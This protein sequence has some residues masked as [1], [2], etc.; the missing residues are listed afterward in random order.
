MI[1]HLTSF[2]VILPFIL[3]F[4]LFC[5]HDTRNPKDSKCLN[6][7]QIQVLTNHVFTKYTLNMM[8]EANK[9]PDLKKKLYFY[10]CLI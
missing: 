3:K 4:D 7:Y 6:P 2:W 1:F 10:S 8:T 9:P 5:L